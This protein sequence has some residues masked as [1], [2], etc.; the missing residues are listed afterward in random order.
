MQQA[1]RVSDMTAFL[2]TG[3]LVEYAPTKQLFVTPRDE[4]TERYISGR[5][6]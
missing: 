4:R 5:F 1:G 6:G 3:D 2:L